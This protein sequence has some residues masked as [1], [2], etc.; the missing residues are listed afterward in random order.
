MTSFTFTYRAHRKSVK[1]EQIEVSCTHTEYRKE[2]FSVYTDDELVVTGEL[3]R[4]V[5]EHGRVSQ[6]ER[7]CEL[8]NTRDPPL[9]HTAD[10]SFTRAA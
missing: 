2:V 3:R 5:S 4:G 1:Y 9:H 6:W 10:A 8:S 7:V